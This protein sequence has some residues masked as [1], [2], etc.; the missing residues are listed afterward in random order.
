MLHRKFMSRIQVSKLWPC[1]YRLVIRVK[2]H[3]WCP[4]CPRKEPQHLEAH[5]SLCESGADS[6]L[7]LPPLPPPLPLP[8]PPAPP[9]PAPLP[10]LLLKPCFTVGIYVEMR[11]TSVTHHDTC[12]CARWRSV[13]GGGWGGLRHAFAPVC[14]K[15]LCLHLCMLTDNRRAGAAQTN[16]FS[17]SLEGGRFSQRG[18]SEQLLAE[19]GQPTDPERLLGQESPMLPSF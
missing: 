2:N 11:Y 15:S 10:L 18:I 13:S 8:P 5:S 6:V 16:E 9:P 4:L 17:P 12:T 19:R 7:L 14:W 3:C 1:L